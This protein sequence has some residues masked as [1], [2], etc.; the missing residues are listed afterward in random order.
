MTA[1][2]LPSDSRVYLDYIMGAGGG[3]GESH[4]RLI[5]M[6]VDASVYMV[7][8]PSIDIFA[9]Y[10][11]PGN[12]DVYDLRLGPGGSRLPP[13]LAAARIFGFVVRIQRRKRSGSVSWGSCIVASWRPASESSP[14]T[15]D[16]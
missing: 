5:I 15:M 14:T 3:Y 9:E 16:A 11:G 1:G 2:V 13:G 10:I 4:E 7:A 6:H 12:A 8:T